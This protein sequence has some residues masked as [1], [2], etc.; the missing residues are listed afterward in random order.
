MLYILPD[1]ITPWLNTLS[2]QC[3]FQSSA[4]RTQE[5]RIHRIFIN[6]AS[7][8]RTEWRRTDWIRRRRAEKGCE[9]KRESKR[10]SPSRSLTRFGSAAPP[11][12]DY[13]P[14]QRERKVALKVAVSE[15]WDGFKSARASIVKNEWKS[16]ARSNRSWCSYSIISSVYRRF[17]AAESLP[18]DY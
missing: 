9:K 10:A 16:S 6:Y 4:A 3:F 17:T 15:G 7:C 12:R 5:G 1:L 2:R 18:K 13:H 14:L 11:R 8:R